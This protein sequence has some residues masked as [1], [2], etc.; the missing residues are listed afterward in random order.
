MF[1]DEN[2]GGEDGEFGGTAFGNEHDVEQSVSDFCF[3]CDWDPARDVPAISDYHVVEINLRCLRVIERDSGGV[4]A[5]FSKCH[6]GASQISERSPRSLHF[7]REFFVHHTAESTG[8]DIHEIADLIAGDAD[9]IDSA[10]LSFDDLFHDGVDAI[11]NAERPRKIVACSEW[12]HGKSRI[13]SAL[14]DPVHDLIQSSIA[15]RRNDQIQIR[16][17][18]RKFFRVTGLSSDMKALGFQ[19]IEA[20]SNCVNVPHR[21]G[22][23]IEN[24]A[25]SHRN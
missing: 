1:P 6:C 21:A 10:R 23:W 8:R 3:R 5:Q 17:L 18:A 11:W 24:N 25:D 2:L 20:L 22:D 9:K 15:A 13:A 14:R 7:W 12:K 19:D 4:T 16:R